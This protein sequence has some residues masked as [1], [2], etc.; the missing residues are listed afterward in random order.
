MKVLTLNPR[1]PIIYLPGM[2]SLVLLPV[3][4]LIFLN[5]HRPSAGLSWMDIVLWG[6]DMVKSFPEDYR[7]F[8]LDRKYIN[9]TLDGDDN[10]N[11]AKLIFARSEVT[12]M[13]HSKDTVNGINI[14]FTDKSKYWAYVNAW[15]ICLSQGVQNYRAYNDD[16]SIIYG[17]FQKMHT[18]PAPEIITSLNIDS[19]ME[20]YSAEY[21]WEQKKKA[22]SLALKVFWAPFLV[23]LL[24]TFFA[25]RKLYLNLG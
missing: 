20:Y 11:R 24:M 15:D 17:R 19:G 5:M 12:K 18:A 4:C 14:H 1:K 8:P 10:R 25:I 6:P 7:Y 16:F 13:L 2:I 22:L 23:F 3:A 21:I 9:I